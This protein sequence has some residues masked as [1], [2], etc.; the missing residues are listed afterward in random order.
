M[1]ALGTLARPYALDPGEPHDRV[2]MRDGARAER[3]SGVTGR[4]LDGELV[5]ETLGVRRT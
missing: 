5:L 3:Q 4:P 1:S 2:L